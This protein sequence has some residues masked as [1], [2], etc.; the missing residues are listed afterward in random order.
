MKLIIF[1]AFVIIVSLAIISIS[2]TLRYSQDQEY[3]KERSDSITKLCIL[4]VI[5]SFCVFFYIIYISYYNSHT[6]LQLGILKR[7]RYAKPVHIPKIY[8]PKSKY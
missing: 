1:I 5:I 4:M 7:N 2:K 8:I 3:I 6:N